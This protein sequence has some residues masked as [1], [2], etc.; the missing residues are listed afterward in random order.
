MAQKGCSSRA[1]GARRMLRGGCGGSENPPDD[2]HAE[3]ACG[4][5]SSVYLSFVV[6][7]EF[8]LLAAVALCRV[9]DGVGCFVWPVAFCV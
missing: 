1:Q 3:R 5:A 8:V 7:V 9:G 4:R 6:Y 2:I